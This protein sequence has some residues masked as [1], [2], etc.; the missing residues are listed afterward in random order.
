MNLNLTQFQNIDR[1]ILNVIKVDPSQFIRSCKIDLCMAPGAATKANL[2]RTFVQ[3]CDRKPGNNTLSCSWASEIDDV[4]VECPENSSYR[5][6]DPCRDFETCE[7]PA[8]CDSDV[9]EVPM[10]FCDPGFLLID[11]NCIAESV[12]DCSTDWSDWS[13]CSASCGDVGEQTREMTDRDQIFID[14]RPCNRQLCPIDLNEI[15]KCDCADG[16]WMCNDGCDWGESCQKSGL[17]ET[18][19]RCLPALVG[20]CKAWGDPHVVTFDGAS[21]DVYGIAS[22]TFAEAGFKNSFT[23][24]QFIVCAPYYMDHTP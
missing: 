7:W 22:Y 18:E 1:F 14:S 4:A 20:E 5:C 16:S 11:G 19:Y 9:Q 12:A 13:E 23:T 2:I 21:N 15:K 17:G 3:E 6:G 10:C 8:T 24:T